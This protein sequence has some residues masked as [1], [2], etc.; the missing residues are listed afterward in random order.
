MLRAEPGP[1]LSEVLDGS[2]SLASV[3]RTDPESG[4]HCLTM[5]NVEHPVELL[6]S[7]HWATFLQQARSSYDLIILDSPPVMHVADALTL[8]DHV[9]SAIFVIA[10]G[11]TRRR[12]VEEALKRFATSGRQVAGVVLSKVPSL[13]TTHSYYSGYA[14]A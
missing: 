9:D 2:Q 13:Q 10:H 4:A 12:T 14:S 1:A 7:S 11:S 3:V 8:A 5:Q 6:S